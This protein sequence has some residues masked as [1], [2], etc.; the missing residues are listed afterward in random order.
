M[1]WLATQP[2]RMAYLQKAMTA[3]KSDEWLEALV[4]TSTS[5]PSASDS[6]P[7]S[8]PG[9]LTEEDIQSWITLRRQQSPN[10]PPKPFFIDVGGGHGHQVIG[11]RDR[12][13]NLFMPSSTGEEEEEEETKHKLLVLEDLPT[14]VSDLALIPGVQISGTNFFTDPQPIQGAHYYYLRRIFHDYPDSGCLT[15]L[16]GLRDAMKDSS[17]VSRILID[18]M[19]LPSTGVSWQATMGDLAMMISLAGKERTADEWQELAKKAGFSVLRT[20]AYDNRE[21]KAVQVWGLAL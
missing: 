5:T 8:G 7:E 1:D 10:D 16:K 4:S 2:K 21:Y 3:M 14:V 11:L 13:P 18:E 15:I 9:I 19:V 20:V 17:E 6:D 12:Y